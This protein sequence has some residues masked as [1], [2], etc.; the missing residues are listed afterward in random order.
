MRDHSR[1]RESYRLDTLGVGA[2]VC[3]QMLALKY[4]KL[5]RLICWEVRAYIGGFQEEAQGGKGEEGSC[6]MVQEAEGS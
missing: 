3:K 5:P 4:S 6:R 1:V 2:T